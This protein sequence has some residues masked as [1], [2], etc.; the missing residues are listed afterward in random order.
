[1]AAT[2]IGRHA[3]ALTFREVADTRTCLLNGAH[4]LVAQDDALAGLQ[5]AV[6][7]PGN[8]EVRPTDGGGIDVQ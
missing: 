5:F 8:L 7:V 6:A 3:D 1:V 4:K 2:D